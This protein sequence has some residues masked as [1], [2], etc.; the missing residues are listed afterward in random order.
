MKTA[1]I[2]TLLLMAA[3]A[4]ALATQ[5]VVAIHVSEV[6][7]ALETMSAGPATPQG[8]GTTGYEWWTPWW[9]YFVMSESVKETL[10]SD[11][12]PFVVV[13]DADITAGSLQNPDGT[14]KYPIMISLA[15]EAIRDDE[16][17]PLA[18]YVSAGGFL[19]LGSSSLTRNPNGTTRSDF[20][21]ASEMGL[22]MANANLQNWFQNTRFL[23]TTQHQLTSHIPDGTLS[24]HM[25]LTSESTAF[26][27]WGGS[28]ADNHYLW[29]VISTG[30]SVLATGDNNHPYLAVTPYQKG[31]FIYDAA[32]Q[33]LIGYGGYAPT[34][35]TYGIF[36]NA[37]QWAFESRNLPIVKVS[38][39]PYAYNAAYVV[40]HDF[41]N[42]QNLINEI[43]SS[44][45][46]DNSVGAR[47][48]YYFSTGTLRVEMNNS[49]STVASLRR[50][51]SLYGAT[52]GSHNGGLPN[53]YWFGLQLS[54]YDYWHWG[55]DY[56]LDETPPGYSS[57]SAYA[58]ASIAISFSDIDGWMS[59]LA[60]NKRTWVSP[61]FNATREGSYQIL[62]SVGAISAGEQKLSPFPHWTVS[63]QISGKHFGFVT[64]PTSDWYVG[65]QVAQALNTGHTW[66]TVYSLVDYY[67]GLGALID[68]YMHEPSTTSLASLYI[69]YSASKP[70]IWPAN[71]D[72]I[73]KWW[74]SRSPVQ[75][76]PSYVISGN[77]LIATVA[78]SGATDPATAIE[79][80]IPDWEL[81]SNGIQVK[82]NGVLTDSSTYRTYGQGIKVKVGTAV[83]TVEISYPLSVGP[84][85]R[86]DSYSVMNG[87]TLSVVAPGV[88]SN[89]TNSGSG[90][91]TA[92][93]VTSTSNGSL[94]LNANG[95]F[96]YT[97]NVGFVGTDHFSYFAIT[98]T[99]QSGVANVTI[100]VQPTW[101]PVAQNDTYGTSQ[102]TTLNVSVPGVLGNDTDG[103]AGSTAMLVTPA[104]NGAL[105]LRDDGSFTYTP[106]AGFTGMDGFTYQQ[107]VGGV[108]S[109]VASVGISVTAA[110]VLFSD[111]FSGEG[112]PDPLWVTALGTWN[113]AN[114]MMGGSGSLW[115]YSF[116]YTIGTWSDYSV[117]GQVQFPAGAYG[118][119]IGGRVNPATGAH[120]GVWIYPEGSG[121]G[122]AVMKLVKFHTWGTWSYVPMAQASLPGVGSTWHTLLLSFQGSRIRA[123]YD[124]VQYIDVT[125]DGF[126]SLPAYTTGGVSLDMW[127]DNTAYVFNVDDILVQSLSTTPVAQNDSYSVAEGTTLTVTA[128]GVL[129]NDTGGSGATAILVSTARNGTLALHEDGSFAYTPNNGFVGADTFT[130]QENF[131]GLSSN[132]ASV[133][134]NVTLGLNSVT[135]NPG[136][137]TGGSGATGTVTLGAPA[138]SGGAMVTL[139]TNN[140]SAVGV[141]ASVNVPMNATTATFPVAT[142]PVTNDTSVVIAATYNNTTQTATLTVIPPIL[143]G[144]TF[145]PSAVTGGNS[146]TGTVTLSGPAPLAGVVVA[147]VS[148]NPSVAN[149]PTSVTVGANATA[150]TFPVS[151]TSVSSNTSVSISATYNG[152]TQSATLTINA[153]VLSSVS[154]SPASVTGGNSATGTVTLGTAAPIGGT[155]VSL[156][157]SNTAAATVPTSITVA[158]NATTATFP[159][160]TTPVGSNTSVTVS[161]T[162]NAVRQTATLTVN[163]VVL[164][165]VAVSPTSVTGGTSS[166]GSV[167][168]NLGAPA[169]GTLVN[170]RSSNPAAA[171]VPGSVTVPA[172]ATT[173]AFSIAT[174]PVASNTAVTI[175]ATY[176]GLTRSTTLTVT[177]PLL[178][179]VSL[180]PTSVTGG[181]PSTGTVALT[182]PASGSGI[183]VSLSSGNT[184][185]ATVPTNV[186]VPMGATT[187]TFTVTTL[188]V[189]SSGS[190]RI[191]ASQGNRTR[192]ASLTVNTPSVSSLVL[193]PTTVRGGAPSK[194]TVTLNGP[195]PQGGASVT[196]SSS[197][198]SVATVPSSLMI[199]AGSSTANFTVTTRTVT[200]TRSVTISA[201]RGVTRSAALTVTP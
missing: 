100:T 128:P 185:R 161:G 31:F 10:R 11:G 23:K 30:A 144:V 78:V 86:E 137:V 84:I 178:S 167:T 101:A 200:L 197:N 182:G 96:T 55:P 76:S 83:S 64:L 43:E 107:N 138:P 122:S 112:G 36:R 56:A 20:A 198:T 92:A 13:T 131:G 146:S 190:V 187:A 104:T 156:A 141:P 48:D 63:T 66:S 143:N 71:A 27:M 53:P 22:H 57:G 133:T 3:S 42:Y 157:S 35:Y 8:T 91:L 19:F 174:S 177:A 49:P 139:S 118:G 196:L 165:S 117:Q 81:A 181:T 115:T 4:S 172:N 9:H 80:F 68:L 151:T 38:P 70:A 169:A 109:N 21:L 90:S 126:D 129:A 58:A 99:A 201:R 82:L 193:N 113:T 46:F 25:P 93:L 98:G 65:A 72:S 125:D 59:G 32:M 195:A 183:V 164:N 150:A 162:Y 120:Y 159:V 130:Y 153:V 180:N 45:Q 186:T 79:V 110:G 173:A 12:T 103:G 14:P 29:Q 15:S 106:Q 85:A 108:L 168:I 51:V 148:G 121:G 47:G 75:I 18:N 50:A 95:S 97:P 188:P 61:Y 5:P 166:A 147:L 127:T 149:V 194:G 192:S 179:S 184:S 160:I 124:G 17:A 123:S 6:T 189:S 16:V 40:R 171:A 111:D 7:Q 67:Y 134:V 69:N 140:S 26:D 132:V 152:A 89:D 199:A 170:L 102:A 105:N 44:S 158:A 52:I 41:E 62:D 145:S 1:F 116:A 163:A 37:I 175:S 88:L 33:P 2:L 77:R 34:M 94:T 87:S 154:V 191:Y 142:T 54:D 28:T 60:T 155:V 176:N 135:V 119:G 39:W 114:G 74:T 73:Y 136:S 24:W